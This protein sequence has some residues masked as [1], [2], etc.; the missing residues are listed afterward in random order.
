MLHTL[1]QPVRPSQPTISLLNLP[2]R[3]PNTQHALFLIFT[4]PRLLRLA[5]HPLAQEIDKLT[6]QNEYKRDGIQK[7][8]G[9]PKDPQTDDDAPEVACQQT[10]IK[11]GSRSKPIQNRYEGIEQR[12]NECITGQIATNLTIPHRSLEA[13]AIKDARLRTI[14]DHPPPANLPND[15][16]KRPLAD[17]KLL[18]H[19]TQSVERGTGQCEQVPLELISGGDIAA[20]DALDVVRG[21]EDAHAADAGQDAEDLGPVVADAEEEEGDGHDDDDG[22][23]VDQLRREDGGVAVGEDSEVVAFHVAEGEDD[24]C[25]EM[26]SFWS[27]LPGLVED[28][29]GCDLVR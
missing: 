18:G 7:M 21:Q 2:L 29:G 22:P 13:I 6:N 25:P 3:R 26:F 14:D 5:K 16:V 11:E 1:T 9:V 8:D 15:L 24:V 20:V 4:Q 27:L 12:Q 28:V 10:D 19:I 23:E 17:Q